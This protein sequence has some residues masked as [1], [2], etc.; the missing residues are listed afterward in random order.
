MIDQVLKN[1][2]NPPKAGSHELYRW[3]DYI[4]L[5]CLT[6]KDHRFSRDGLVESIAE[7]VDTNSDDSL[8][9]QEEEEFDEPIAT[10][11][12]TDAAVVNDKHEQHSANCFKHL[13][14][15]EKAFSECWP[16]TLDEH[17]FEIRIKP[18]LTEIQHFYL[19]LLLSASLSYVPKKRWRGLTGLLE[20]A[21]TEIMKRLMPNGAEVH[22]FG[23]AETKRYTGHLFDRLTKLANDVRG[24]LELKKHH[25][26]EHDS[27]DSGLDVVA[28]H[29]LGDE[30]K[31]IPIAFA[32]CGCTASGWPNKMLEASPARLAGHLNTFHEWA[33]YYFMPLDLSTEV[34]DVMDWQMFSDFSRAIVIDRMRFVRLTL[35]YDIPPAPI[36]AY[37]YVNEAHALQ[38]S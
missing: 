16:F 34:D 15:R 13:R 38:L 3:C 27:G 4:E 11:S 29:G 1:L 21:S 5:R 31:G 35:A 8:I 7:N 24:S 14:W 20:K 32:Q 30:R 18:E 6:H 2:T 22:P 23:A 26:A 17:A 36:T 25:F 9:D 10:T 37:E 19:S 28:W 33:T 12:E